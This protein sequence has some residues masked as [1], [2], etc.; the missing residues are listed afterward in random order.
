LFFHSLAISSATGGLLVNGYM[1]SDLKTFI[2]LNCQLPVGDDL[3]CAPH[4]MFAKEN[5]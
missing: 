5:Y 2:T 3:M 1:A 4:I